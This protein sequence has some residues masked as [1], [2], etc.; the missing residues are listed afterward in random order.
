[1]KTGKQFNPQFSLGGLGGRVEHWNWEDSLMWAFD[2]SGPT[3]TQHHDIEVLPN[4]NVL[5]LAIEAKGSL[6]PIQAG[7]DPALI[8]NN[9]VWSE[10]LVEVKPLGP[11]SAEV[12]WEW[13]A[14][15]H[16]VQD[17]DA[18]ALNYGVVQDHPELIDLN[19]VPGIVSRDWLHA[20][21]VAYNAELDQVMLSIANFNEFWIID[22]STT[23]AESAGHSGGLR[24]KGGDLLYRW[25]NP[26]TYRRGDSTDQKLL[27]QHD[28]HWIGAGLQDS[29]KVILFNNGVGRAYSSVEIISL[30][31]SAPG[32]YL[33]APGQPYGP[34]ASDFI[35]TA[36]PPGSFFSK[37]M[38]SASRL[39]NGNLLIS[40]GADG[41][42]FEIDGSGQQVWRY[43][44]PV[45]SQGITPQGTTPAPGI[46][47]VFRM[48]RYAPDFSGFDGRDLSPGDPLEPG[49]N[50]ND[51]L[52]VLTGQE[53]SPEASGWHIYPN[54]VDD[55]FILETGNAR[56][57]SILVHD[58][59]GN[60]LFAG[61]VSRNIRIETGGWPSGI[62]QVTGSNNFR[63]RV[64]KIVH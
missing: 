44:S 47:T 11:D 39:P 63:A 2:Y 23:T 42:G 25:G 56:P 6:E 33:L 35:W 19:F 1:M 37:I 32:E 36:N 16:L 57:V 51:C 59:M 54:P 12:V 9:T 18:Q 64:L 62:Y 48:R 13:H 31:Q 41:Y 15:D 5:L 34:A 46:S 50:I 10:Y 24:G 61:E 22:H 52:A 14:W 49:F 27:F 55:F 58:L 53:G 60:V 3:W 40:H 8:S 7:R 29:G 17:F 20:N 43:Q 26:V 28:A 30:P 21:S 38:S 4:G 45:T